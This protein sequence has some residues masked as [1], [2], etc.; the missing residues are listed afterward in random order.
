MPKVTFNYYGGKKIGLLIVG[1]FALLGL[2][3][4]LLVPKLIYP[5]ESSTA[6]ASHVQFILPIIMLIFFIIG[7]T[8]S[9]YWRKNHYK[10]SIKKSQENYYSVKVLNRNNRKSVDISDDDKI[11]FLESRLVKTRRMAESDPS[12]L[13]EL[14]KRLVTLSILYKQKD[15]R[16]SKEYLEEAQAIINKNNF[17]KSKEGEEVASFVNKVKRNI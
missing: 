2:I 13:I 3:I 16:K 4:S 17:P 8:L 5:R 1:I 15:L 9:M 10:G 7:T 14:A 12:A 6:Y 11:N